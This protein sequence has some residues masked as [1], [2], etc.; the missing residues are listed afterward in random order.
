MNKRLKVVINVLDNVAKYPET[1]DYINNKMK[2]VCE[3]ESMSA[4]G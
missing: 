1:K 4:E 3:G 2:E